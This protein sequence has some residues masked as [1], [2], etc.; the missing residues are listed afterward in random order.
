MKSASLPSI[1]VEAEFR[2]ELE[3]ALAE[4]E[5]VSAFV[6]A[7]VRQALRKRQ[8]D[9]EFHARGLA[10]IAK[11]REDG[12]S[13]SPEEVIAKL[14]ARTEAARAEQARRRSSK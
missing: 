8:L 3:G 4:G 12:I 14:R 5:T 11:W 2:E 1:R 7:S 9:A 6:E 10:A 13:S